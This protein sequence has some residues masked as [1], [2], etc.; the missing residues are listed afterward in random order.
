MEDHLKVHILVNNK[1]QNI[2]D[3]LDFYLQA[4]ID[5][6]LAD[7][8]G[9]TTIIA[10]FA[11]VEITFGFFFQDNFYFPMWIRAPKKENG[12]SFLMSRSLKCEY[13]RPKDMSICPHI[14]TCFVYM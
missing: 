7:Y 9:A 14:R 8:M 2:L 10:Y 1:L 6:F 11:D 5:P 4:I 3:T 13:Q 12:E